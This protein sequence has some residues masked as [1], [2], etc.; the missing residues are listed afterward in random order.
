MV[1]PSLKMQKMAGKNKASLVTDLTGMPTAS[2]HYADF[3]EQVC[4]DLLETSDKQIDLIKQ[5]GKS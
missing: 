1:D 4:D 2:D 5:K 3:I